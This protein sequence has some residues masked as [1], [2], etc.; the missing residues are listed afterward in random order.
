MLTSRKAL[1]PRRALFLAACVTGLAVALAWPG[2]HYP[3]RTGALLLAA[4]TAVLGVL[5]AVPKLQVAPLTGL[6]ESERFDLENKARATI[7]QILAGA[8]LIG[9]L[10]FTW[11]TVRVSEERI[12]AERE[13]SD[14]QRRIQ[15]FGQLSGERYLRVET[16]ILKLT[17]DVNTRYDSTRLANAKGKAKSNYLKDLWEQL[18][19]SQQMTFEIAKDDERLFE[20]I[21]A[22]NA[23]FPTTDQLRVLTGNLSNYQV[24]DTPSPGSGVS[25]KKL[26]DWKAKEDTAVQK[27]VEQNYGRPMDALIKYLSRQKF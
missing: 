12:S 8:V 4:L 16:H 23:A 15:L 25:G 9:G 6:S 2:L 22:I 19:W 21:G 7:A 17:A 26:E 1:S 14:R 3:W 24:M 18:H 11:R 5:Y 27:F 20:T 13:A 10:Y